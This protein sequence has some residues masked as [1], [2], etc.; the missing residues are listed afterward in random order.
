MSS[1]NLTVDVIVT[2]DRCRCCGRTQLDILDAALSMRTLAG[3]RFFGQHL[4]T[5]WRFT[6]GNLKDFMC[7]FCQLDVQ[8]LET[9]VEAAGG[10]AAWRRKVFAAARAAA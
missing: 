8:R 10:P 7:W 3:A 2:L 9:E 6:L 4:R 5:R 1:A